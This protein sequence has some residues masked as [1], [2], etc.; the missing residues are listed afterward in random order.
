MQRRA[1]GARLI[2]RCG[3]TVPHRAINPAPVEGP[4]TV[5]SR[6]RPRTDRGAAHG[7]TPRTTPS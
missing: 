6:A 4:R 7:A 5:R 3:A 2:A 1:A